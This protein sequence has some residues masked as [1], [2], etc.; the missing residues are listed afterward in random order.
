MIPKSDYLLAAAG[1]TDTLRGSV[2]QNGI[3]DAIQFMPSGAHTITPMIDGQY[4][5]INIQVNEELA[6]KL[7]AELQA[8]RQQAK[9]GN[10]DMPYID[11]NHDDA[12]A[13]G[14]PTEIY[15]AGTSRDNGGIWMKVNWTHAGKAAL[16]GKMY[17]RFSPCWLMDKNYKPLGITANMGGLVNCAA[18][19]TIK[20]IVAKGAP[21]IR[22]PASASD[23]YSA[24]EARHF[25]TGASFA[26]AS[27]A[28]A[29]ENPA[30][31]AA[32][33]REKEALNN[34]SFVVEARAMAVQRGISV[35]DA[36]VCLARSNFPLYEQ[37]LAS[38]AKQTQKMVIARK[39]PDGR[40]RY[41]QAV[42][43]KQAE[44]MKFEEAAQSVCC[45]HPELYE[46]YRR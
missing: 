25:Q 14:E 18:F 7:N 39:G 27:I 17:R 23:F 29:K 37:Y 21:T 40:R 38:Q 41:L 22:R 19:Q 46:E 42:Q 16:E 5:T 8:M 24:V 28:V 26:E 32:F 12:E 33:E 15:W 13:S 6:Q 9:L 1:F 20:P 10:G 45:S 2:I 30:A 3:P 4:K 36:Q 44:G 34:H 11:F 31:A 35:N 43:A